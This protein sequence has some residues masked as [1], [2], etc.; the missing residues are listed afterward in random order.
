MLQLSETS[1]RARVGMIIGVASLFMVLIGVILI[2]SKKERMLEDRYSFVRM[3][4]ESAYTILAHF[5]ALEQQGRL[6]TQQAQEQAKNMIKVLRY[7]GSNYFWINDS[8]PTMIMH[9]LKPALD[10]KD[11]TEVTD[12]AGKRLFVAMVTALQQADDA[13]VEYHWTKPNATEPSPKVSSV[14]KFQ[15]WGWIIGSGIYIDDVDEIFKGDARTAAIYLMGFVALT[16]VFGL[17]VGRS[18]LNALGC[19]PKDLAHMAGRVAR[20]NLVIGDKTLDKARKSHADSIVNAMLQMTQSLQQL[21]QEI[22]QQSQHMGQASQKLLKMSN[23]LTRGAGDMRSHANQACDTSKEVSQKMTEVSAAVG[24]S[25]ENL[26]TISHTIANMSSDMSAISAAS[27]QADAGLSGVATAVK[28]V[29]GS[30]EHLYEG[31]NQN[32]DAVHTVREAVTELALAVREMRQRCTSASQGS[33][34]AQQ[35]V[36]TTNRLAGELEKSALEIGKVVGL[37]ND[38]AEQTNML[39]LNA[40]I[41]AAGAGESGKGFAVVANEVKELARQT[42]EATFNI[43]HQ[44]DNIQDSSGQVARSSAEMTKVIQR[45]HEENASINQVADEQ[46]SILTRVSETMDLTATN[47]DGLSKQMGT[48]TGQMG[49]A[50]RSLGEIAQGIGEVAARVSES[51]S[52]VGMIN[53]QVEEASLTQGQIS[54]FVTEAAETTRRVALTMD[55][56]GHVTSEFEGISQEVSDY[57]EQLAQTS[58]KLNEMV[59]RFTVA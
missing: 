54:D 13:L 44:V 15:P 11:L 55:N 12:Q 19:E 7:D 29:D 8:H 22:T 51:S 42:A 31:A 26:Y 16:L 50:S 49:E 17:L 39:A 10:G 2:A 9:P 18:I 36:Q 40:S 25:T 45:I 20:G 48:L 52:G 57:A 37:I 27:E 43:G 32:R 5:N 46:E 6:S 35:Q 30:L 59:R 3:Q 1:L 38:I 58:G 34:Q 23:L 4:V 53:H 21:V 24:N 28:L 33:E 41:E 56:I 14:K 47:T